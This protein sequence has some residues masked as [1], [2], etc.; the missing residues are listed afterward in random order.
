[1]QHAGRPENPLD[2]MRIM[3]NKVQSGSCANARLCQAVLGQRKAVRAAWKRSSS[4]FCR[5]HGKGRDHALLLGH[6]AR[7]RYHTCRCEHR[8]RPRIACPAFFCGGWGF[9]CPARFLAGL[10]TCPARSSAGSSIVCCPSSSFPPSPSIPLSPA[11]IRVNLPRAL[12][13]VSGL[14]A[15]CRVQWINLPT[16]S[17]CIRRRYD[18]CSFRLVHRKCA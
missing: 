13:G 3:H 6:P 5:G 2:G 12:P 9:G 15:A 1:L 17:I 7:L 16:K 14:F 18:V 10:T 11:L 4:P 8:A